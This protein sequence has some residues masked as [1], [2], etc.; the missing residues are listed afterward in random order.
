P[1]AAAGARGG[2]QRGDPAGRRGGALLGHAVREEHGDERGAGG[3]VHRAGRLGGGGGGRRGRAG[4]GDAGREGAGGVPGGERRRDERAVH[5]ARAAGVL[6]RAERPGAGGGRGVL[7]VRRAAAA[8]AVRAGQV[9]QATGEEPVAR[10]GR[11]GGDDV[12]LRS[13]FFAGGVERDGDAEPD[14]ERAAAHGRGRQERG[15][16]GRRLAVLLPAA[17]TG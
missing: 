1:D 14:V 7:D 11:A 17:G 9:D 12:L 16:E 2:G 15:A 5:A 10:Q 3:G 13:A 4:G 6:R 8:A